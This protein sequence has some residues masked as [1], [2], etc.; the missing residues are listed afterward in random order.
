MKAVVLTVAKLC[1]HVLVAVVLVGIVLPL[2]VLGVVIF[3]A[4]AIAKNHADE[5]E[6]RQLAVDASRAACRRGTFDD[7]DAE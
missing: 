7:E 1:L 6:R 4:A 3:V 2:F 5:A